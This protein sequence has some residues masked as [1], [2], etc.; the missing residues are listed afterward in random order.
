LGVIRSRLGTQE[1]QFLATVLLGSGVLFVACLFGAA[2]LAGGLADAVADGHIQLPQS[3]TYYF[4]RHTTNVLL[5]VF[6]IKMAAVFMFSTCTI[7]LRTAIFP[8]WVAFVGYSCGLV[9]LV[10]ITNWK[11]IALLFPIWVLL[12]SVVILAAEFGGRP[13]EM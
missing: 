5:N 7:G 2:A 10:V 13:R 1:D 4:G 3:E 6:A 11:W 8:R 9:L 12:V